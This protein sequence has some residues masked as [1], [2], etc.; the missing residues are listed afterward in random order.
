MNIRLNTDGEHAILVRDEMLIRGIQPAPVPL[1]YERNIVTFDGEQ[2]LARSYFDE[3]KDPPVVHF[4]GGIPEFGSRDVFRQ[5][6][7]DTYRRI[8]G[9]FIAD[10]EPQWAS[11]RFA[12]HSG[13]SAKERDAAATWF[14]DA[15]AVAS[16]LY[17][18]I[19][20]DWANFPAD[21]FSRLMLRLE[22]FY[23]CG[24][25]YAGGNGNKPYDVPAYHQMV[26]RYCAKVKN[27]GRQMIDCEPFLCPV[28]SNN[29]LVHPD[30]MR[31]M[32]GMWENKG[33]A[34]GNLWVPA[35]TEAQ[36]KQSVAWIDTM[37]DVFRGE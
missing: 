18:F 8:G 30:L 33:C 7:V 27:F 28:D 26:R 2:G 13:A 5:A 12:S 11:P 4:N 24:Y 16:G 37:L 34:N 31:G 35:D 17:G 21:S 25:W 23:P 20:D 6:L 1:V 15:A 29:V 10:I 14:E 9:R 36:A 3:T 32:I 19:F 22:K